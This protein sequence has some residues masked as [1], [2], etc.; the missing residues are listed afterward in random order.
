MVALAKWKRKVRNRD[1]NRCM[2]CNTKQDLTVHHILPK[3]L[4]PE[5]V[6]QL[7][8]MITLCTSCHKHYHDVFLEGDNT[9]TN[10]ETLKEWLRTNFPE[11]RMKR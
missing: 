3:M 2:K 10:W 5:L 4:Y 11:I 9:K 1:G 8:N 6:D 7:D